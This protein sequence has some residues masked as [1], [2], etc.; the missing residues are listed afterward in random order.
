M[1]RVALEQRRGVWFPQSWTLTAS[2]STPM[3]LVG[4]VASSRSGPAVIFL[5]LA[6]RGGV[7]M[8]PHRIALQLLLE[9]GVTELRSESS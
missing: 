2:L 5:H 1:P 7:V 3:K 4:L 8:G 6:G 9:R